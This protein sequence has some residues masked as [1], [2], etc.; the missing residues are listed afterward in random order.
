[1]GTVYLA[2]HTRMAR[3]VALKVIHT[4]LLQNSNIVQRFQQEVKAASRLNHPNIVTAFD[5]DEA[6]TSDRIH[7]LVME[8]VKG[9]NLAEYCNRLGGSLPVAEA[10]HCVQQAAVGLQHAWEQ[11]MVHRDL[12]PHNLMRS[13]QGQIKILDF[14]LARLSARPDDPQNS[15]TVLTSPGMVMGTVDYMAPEQV[16][17]SRTV[18]IRADIYSLGCTLYQ[19]LTGRLPYPGGS[20][21]DKLC[22]LAAGPPP[23]KSLR[24]D[25]P[26]VL[27]AVVEKMMAPRPE[28]RFATPAAL[29]AALEP[30]STP[31]DSSSAQNMRF[32]PA[33]PARRSRRPL[34]LAAAA[35][36]LFGLAVVLAIVLGFPGRKQGHV[37]VVSDDPAVRISVQRNGETLALLWPQDQQTFALD[38]GEYSLHLEGDPKGLKIEQPPGR[39]H[40][41]E[42]A[43]QQIIVRRL[44]AGPPDKTPPPLAA[45]RVNSPS[46]KPPAAKVAPAPPRRG[47]V[48]DYREVH[49]VDAR[50]LQKWM[51]ELPDQQFHPIFLNVQ[52]GTKPSRFNAVA[53]RDNKRPSFQ[54]HMNQPPSNL[55]QLTEKMRGSSYPFEVCEYF[56]GQEVKLALL[57]MSGKV[58]G[59]QYTV[60][61][62]KMAAWLKIQAAQESL[63]PTSFSTILRKPGF[64]M[65]RCLLGP[66]KSARWEARLD[67]D[68]GQL[69]ALMSKYREKKWR[70]DVLVARWT[71]NEYR[72]L[73]SAIELKGP[74]EWSF[75]MDLSTS[76]YEKA[77]DDQ[78]RRGFFPMRVTSYG[79]QQHPSYAVV[80]AA[81]QSASAAAPPA[82]QKPPAVN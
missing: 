36:V 79:D 38:T 17:D 37:T 48:L 71:G 10:C 45:V 15:D 54:F 68:A 24:P 14:G 43:T 52:A 25:V 20:T 29:A 65:V 62:P 28:D 60:A 33:A 46:P 53:I 31:S 55:Q 13:S 70:P 3:R 81:Y 44:P 32:G 75:Q 8:Y 73:L 78:K 63:R 5:A 57:A 74:R 51:E 47:P 22:R 77:L 64:L 26:D 69:Q 58:R 80:W 16:D 30:F 9:E 61:A 40:L 21:I 19:L 1:M 72:F 76:D 6:G 35:V 56:E 42:G 11:G 2:E 12:K 18:D 23:L 41:E 7:F 34:M 66:A 50:T 49:G 4:Q 59:A 27:I 67:Q 39:L 82:Q